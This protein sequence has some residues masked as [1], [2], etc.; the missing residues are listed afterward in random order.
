M[1]M[2]NFI[3]KFL[4]QKGLTQ[5]EVAEA[6]GMTTAGLSRAIKGSATKETIDRVA[7]YLGVESEVLIDHTILVAKY[8]SDKTPLHFGDVEVPCYVLEDGTRVFSGRGMQK[9]IGYESKSGQWM[10]SFLRTDGLSPYFY[11][12]KNGLIEQLQSPIKFKRNNA[13]GSQSMT[14][15]YDATLLIDICSAIIDANRAGD[16]NDINIV[17]HADIIIR[18]VAKTGIIALVDEAT[19]YD[20]AKERAKD[21]LQN[22]LKLFLNKEAAAWVKMFDDDFFETLYKMRNWTWTQTSKRPGIVGKWIND[23]VYERIAP[24]IFNE[25]Q[26][27]NPKNEKGNRRYK[28]HQFFT[29][30]V[31]KPKLKQ[32]L[33][34]VKLLA[35]A[36]GYNWAKFMHLLDK[37]YPKQYQEQDL[38]DDSDFDEV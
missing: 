23:I 33:D 4:D 25:I 10:N 22:Y 24:M 34:G 27:L 35:K 15:G 12:E 20:K 26:L 21:E 30:D 32:H 37:A 38:F 19:G 36:S 9:A 6:I 7:K 3:K 17:A 8:S 16:F 31:G 1:F 11:A 28:Y 18:A 2:R 29:S 13:G 14:Y 5:K